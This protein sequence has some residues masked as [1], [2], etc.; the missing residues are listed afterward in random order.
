MTD[1]TPS[2]TFTPI[3]EVSEPDSRAEAPSGEIQPVSGSDGNPDS[4]VTDSALGQLQPPS[5]PERDFN[6]DQGPMPASTQPPS[7]TLRQPS[8]RLPFVTPPPPP[9]PPIPW[10]PKAG[11]SHRVLQSSTLSA[12]ATAFVPRS[13]AHPHFQGPSNCNL[14][15]QGPPRRSGS[16]PEEQFGPLIIPPGQPFAQGQ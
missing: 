6:H 7:S 14:G 1:F 16:V 12:E 11:R 5:N 2:R 4:E 15:G 10:A 8:T 13:R 9:T 3:T